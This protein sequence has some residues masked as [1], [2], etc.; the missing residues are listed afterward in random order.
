MSA[1]NSREIFSSVKIETFETDET[2]NN[3]IPD[4]M[5]MSSCSEEG[6][7]DGFETLLSAIRYCGRS[8]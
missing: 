2:S 3:D 4:E 5:A 8:C 6:V 1:L 7:K